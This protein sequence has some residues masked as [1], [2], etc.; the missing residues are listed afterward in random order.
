M[1]AGKK[2]TTPDNHLPQKFL[3]VGVA[4]QKKRGEALGIQLPAK[5]YV[6]VRARSWQPKNIVKDRVRDE[7]KK[8]GL[9]AVHDT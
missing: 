3:C 7:Q 6:C 5:N 8:G 4:G 2:K 1:C 9:P